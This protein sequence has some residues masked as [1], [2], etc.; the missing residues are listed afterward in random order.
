[1]TM[2]A[3]SSEVVD[4]LAERVGDL[5]RGTAG[6]EFHRGNQSPGPLSEASSGGEAPVK[7]ELD[8]K[9][10]AIKPN[11]ELEDMRR[12]LH[13]LEEREPHVQNN[14]CEL[15]EQVSNLKQ[16]ANSVEAALQDKVTKIKSIMGSLHK[17]VKSSA[18]L[19]TYR[20]ERL[21]QD[22]VRLR[23]DFCAFWKGR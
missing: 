1:M 13:W 5:E 6:P 14:L 2:A 10:V 19:S 22:L 9:T 11:E 15:A 23:P 21:E 8:G 4:D 20:F 18:E 7:G 17:E 3:L 12:R 16:Q